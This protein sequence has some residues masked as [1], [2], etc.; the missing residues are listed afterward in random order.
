MQS[1][2]SCL[3]PET[4]LLVV[5]HNP[6]TAAFCQN[7]LFM[8]DGRLYDQEPDSISAQEQGENAGST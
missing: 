8:K 7:G 6:K 1:L 2:M 4:V 5:T 3:N